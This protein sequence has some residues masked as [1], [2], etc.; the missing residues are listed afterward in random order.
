MNDLLNIENKILII[1]LFFYSFV[2]ISLV[3]SVPLFIF[4]A[5]HHSDFPAAEIIQTQCV[6]NTVSSFTPLPGNAGASEKIFMDLFQDFF[7]ENEIVIA[8]IIH[9]MIT[10]YFSI[11]IGAIVYFCSKK[12]SSANR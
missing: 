9:R 7:F 6:A 11:I 3:F 12:R 8:M 4:K 10:F 2:Q 1:K 5:F